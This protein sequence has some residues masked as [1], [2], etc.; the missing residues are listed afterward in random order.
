MRTDGRMDR[1]EETNSRFS[2]FLRMPLINDQ[3]TFPIYRGPTSYG[4]FLSPSGWMY[5]QTTELPSL[6]VSLAYYAV[7]III[8][9]ICYAVR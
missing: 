3:G 6:P 4:K 7:D 5:T 8:T 9:A 1:H 2:Q